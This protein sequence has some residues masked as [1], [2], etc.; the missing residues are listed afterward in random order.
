MSRC[1][2]MFSGGLDSTTVLSWAVSKYDQVQ[3]LSFDYGQRNRVEMKLA[4][5]TARRL[6][7]PRTVLKVDL[8][9]IGGS[10]LTDPSRPLPR[11]EDSMRKGVPPA[12]YVPFRNGVFLSLAAAWAEANGFTDI[13]CGF[14]VLDSPDYPDTTERFV[15]AM[16]A[17]VN[18]GTRAAMGGPTMRIQAPFI[19]MDKTAI[20]RA[21]L[22]LGT[23]YSLSYS[24][25]AGETVPCGECAACRLRAAAWREIGREDPL[26]TRLKKE[27]KI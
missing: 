1:A 25:Y 17:A 27:G 14:H 16:E 9:R 8:K 4:A 12:T 22:E 6:N 23:D 7:V 10:A 3:A 26:I 5:R 18:A 11:Y 13:A 21:G 20:I 15:K 24:C 19:G 2:V